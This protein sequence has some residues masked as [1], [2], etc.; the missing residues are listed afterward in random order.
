MRR[1]I[2]VGMILV[3]G[4]AISGCTTPPTYD[5]GPVVML[6]QNYEGRWQSIS[7]ADSLT[8]SINGSVFGTAGCEAFSGAYSESIADIRSIDGLIFDNSRCGE[9]IES[10]IRDTVAGRFTLE[11]SS[12]DHL[13]ITSE[14]T[15]NVAEFARVPLE[16]SDLRGDWLL[17]SGNDNV[18]EIALDNIN[19][20][21]SLFIDEHGI[22]GTDDC[23]S[24][25]Y[26]Y[27]G[28]EEPSIFDAEFPL[29]KI[30][31]TAVGCIIVE[32]GKTPAP[33]GSYTRA[34][35]SVT[36]AAFE[37]DGLVLSGP[38]TVLRFIEKPVK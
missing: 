5:S 35:S 3:T 13:S 33:S 4:L 36:D 37:G 27:A 32:R 14:Q 29:E 11:L 7:G 23:N 38:A 10:E 34:L 24:L 31:S 1:L 16:V 21:M 8:L 2:A 20:Q 12:N 22:S 18:A 17:T 26:I 19:G 30:V 9:D 15:N 28:P 6:P 25:G